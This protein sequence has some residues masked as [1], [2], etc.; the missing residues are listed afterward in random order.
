MR[1]I[2]PSVGALFLACAKPAPPVVPGPLLAAE[3]AIPVDTMAN[4]CDALQS[5]LATW[6]ECAN[7][8][9]DE[10]EMVDSWIEEAKLDFA[11]GA[12][13]T[14]EPNAQLALAARCHKATVSV[15]AATERCHNGKRPRRD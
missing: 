5:A 1:L 15:Q 7:L 9:K 10:I 12:K 2:L 11:A 3:G 8:E 6:K 14:I 4:E 13:A